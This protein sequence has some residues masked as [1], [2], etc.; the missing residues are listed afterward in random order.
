VKEEENFLSSEHSD[1][2][3][4]QQSKSQSASTT[5]N[6]RLPKKVENLRA[7]FFVSLRNISTAG[8]SLTLSTGSSAGH[9]P[10]ASNRD[11]ELQTHDREKVNNCVQ[12]FLT[13]IREIFKKKEAIEWI[14]ASQQEDVF[15]NL[16][17]ILAVVQDVKSKFG[18]LT[19][20][21]RSRTF[22]ADQSAIMIKLAVMSLSREV[23]GLVE[24]LKERESAADRV[25]RDVCA[26][27]EGGAALAGS[28]RGPSPRRA[29][30][31]RATPS[32]PSASCGACSASRS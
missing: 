6:S 14:P 1:K 17:Q 32:A 25:D 9:T 18:L 21:S 27:L 19:E 31:S 20:Q 24:H 23:T 29:G 10:S 30:S 2:L 13:M 4:L 26:A 11:F 3:C 28:V 22:R 15:S 7:P 8:S 12:L 16:K 5:L